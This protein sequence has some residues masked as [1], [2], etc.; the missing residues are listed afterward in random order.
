M[1]FEICS[2]MAIV[3][4]AGLGHNTDAAASESLLEQWYE[5]AV[6]YTNLFTR[7]DWTSN[8]STLFS[9]TSAA[10]QMAVSSLAAMDLVAYDTILY[11]V[12]GEAQD[13]INI[14][15]YKANLALKQL[16]DDAARK[17]AIDGTTGVE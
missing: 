13:L 7:F 8:A 4:K 2:S 11:F 1:A 10:L 12:R 17:F 15:E 14:L 3:Q 16:Q 5:E 9:S 6:A